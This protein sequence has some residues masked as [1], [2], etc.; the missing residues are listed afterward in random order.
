[1][2]F[3]IGMKIVEKKYVVKESDDVADNNKVNASSITSGVS[4]VFTSELPLVPKKLTLEKVSLAS[5][6]VHGES[7]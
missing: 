5:N 2:I 7:T 4:E 3:C 1:M 6:C